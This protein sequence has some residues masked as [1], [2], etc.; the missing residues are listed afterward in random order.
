M[1]LIILGNGFDLHH[2]YKTS[3]N[4]FR[5]FLKESKK[6]ENNLLVNNIDKILKTKETDLQWNNFEE[7]VG[8]R[9]NPDILFDDMKDINIVELIEQFTGKFHKYLVSIIK[10]SD[11]KLNQNLIKEFNVTSSLLTFNYTSF[12]SLYLNKNFVDILHIHGELTK[13]NLPIIGYYYKIKQKINSTDYSIKYGKRLIHKPALALKQNEIDLDKVISNH[14]N[15]WKNKITEIVVIGFSFGESDNHIYDILD[16]IMIT[17]TKEINIPSSLSND[18][19]LIKFKIYNFNE[20]ESII[21]IKKIKKK[22]SEM[23]RRI[24]VNI[25]GVGFSSLKKDLIT[26]ELV[27]Y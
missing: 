27:N 17:Q 22:F 2:N 6:D 5:S 7:I 21:L 18:I 12:Y 13:N 24:S 9:L 11:D 14:T 23:N 8:H 4:D 25:T 1:K 26:F 10:K 15:K 19:K 3:F 16:K 20:K